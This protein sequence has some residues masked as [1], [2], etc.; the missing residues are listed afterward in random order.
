[1]KGG[2]MPMVYQIGIALSFHVI[3]FVTGFISAL[4]LGTVSSSKMRDGMFKK[5]GFVFCYVVAVI[6]D[7]YGGYVGFSLPVKV[8]PV[9]VTYAI[10]TELVS[11][12]ENIAKI[13]PDLKISKLREI[14]QVK[15]K[16]DN[17][18]SK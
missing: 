12:L 1:M 16:K 17:D 3:D 7:V 10:M 5:V 13:N 8:L 18:E 9:I 11:I 14:F 6:I 4:K 15:D 2:F